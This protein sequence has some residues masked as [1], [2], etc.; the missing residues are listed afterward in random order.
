MHEHSGLTEA[1]IYESANYSRTVNQRYLECLMNDPTDHERGYKAARAF[2]QNWEEIKSDLEHGRYNRVPGDQSIKLLARQKVQP[3]EAAYLVERTHRGEAPP[4]QP[5][6][7][8]HRWSQ[9]SHRTGAGCREKRNQ[10][11]LE[12]RRAAGD[13]PQL[14][15]M[16][17]SMPPDEM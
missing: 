2:Q 6:A 17:D 11:R 9:V 7:T 14:A 16:Q 12:A 4:A 8:E 5:S 3:A 13:L 15:Y 10:A 1:A